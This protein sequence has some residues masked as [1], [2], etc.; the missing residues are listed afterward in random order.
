LVNV[1]AARSLADHAL[2][3]AEIPIPPRTAVDA[4]FA[5]LRAMGV[6]RHLDVPFDVDLGEL[7]AGHHVVVRGIERGPGEAVLHYE[8]VP[9]VQ[10]RER[11]DKG[12]FFWYWMVSASD[13]AG[14]E[15]AE[16]NTGGFD[17]SGQGPSS[18]GTRDLG[19]VIPAAANRLVLDFQ[20]PWDHTP[21]PGVCTSLTIELATGAVTAVRV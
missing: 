16:N 8:F 9:A 19:G 15:Y 13:D 6:H 21:E 2:G 14:T 10:D 18:H 12:P 11:R 20:P 4:Y 3:M 7:V 1:V 5:R 17:P